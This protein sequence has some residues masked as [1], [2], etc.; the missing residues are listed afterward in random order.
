M[1]QNFFYSSIHFFHTFLHIRQNL[2]WHKKKYLL[3]FIFIE[4]KRNLHSAN[5]SAAIYYF[6]QFCQNSKF[7]QK[8]HFFKNFFYYTKFFT[9][10]KNVFYFFNVFFYIL[11]IYINI[12]SIFLN[13]LFFKKISIESPFYQDF[14]H[15]LNNFFFT[16]LPKFK[17]LQN[18]TYCFQI[19]LESSNLSQL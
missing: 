6:T 2:I 5:I 18:F 7:R 12:N 1:I 9:I 11:F 16:F 15:L 14:F 17:R 3:F 8:L 19:S 4:L 13:N 10:I